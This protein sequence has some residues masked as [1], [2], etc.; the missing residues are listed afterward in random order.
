MRFERSR[1]YEYFDTKIIQIGPLQPVIWP[2]EDC[3]STGGAQI[4]GG[5]KMGPDGPPG[6]KIDTMFYRGYKHLHKKE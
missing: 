1:F 2:L 5:P 6:L 3:G 4:F